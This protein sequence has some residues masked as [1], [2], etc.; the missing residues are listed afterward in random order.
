MVAGNRFVCSQGILERRVEQRISHWKRKMRIYVGNL[1]Y[2]MRDDD[3]FESFEEFGAV[4]AAEVMM[5]RDTG[6][7]RGFG[8]VE[9][10]DEAAANA[11]IAALNGKE[12]NGRPLT[13]N[14]ARP[15]TEGGGDR[16]GGGG[17][18]RY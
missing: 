1:P 8:F 4:Q 5:E 18:G 17:R 16:R 10:E 15:R 12:M 6:R 7:S 11:A 13:V 3:L 2:S 9:M 14:E